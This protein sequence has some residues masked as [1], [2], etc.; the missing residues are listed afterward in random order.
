M[1]T[2]VNLEDL[3]LSEI[4]T[5]VRLL[6]D[7]TSMNCLK[8]SNSEKWEKNDGCQR[9]KGGRA[10]EFLIRGYGFSYSSWIHSSG[11]LCHSVSAVNSTVWYT[12]ESVNR[13]CIQAIVLT[14]IKFLKRVNPCPQERSGSM[15]GT[16]EQTSILSVIVA[17]ETF[18]CVWCYQIL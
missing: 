16:Q 13:A 4:V 15:M 14:I 6:H 5:A 17:L 18:F 7:S 2:W 3:K 11:L 1:T 8:Q 12:Q 10:G 9:L